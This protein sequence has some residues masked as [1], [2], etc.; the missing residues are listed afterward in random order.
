MTYKALTGPMKTHKDLKGP[1]QTYQDLHHRAARGNSSRC[2]P[3]PEAPQRFPE[4]ALRLR[5]RLGSL[6]GA[7][8]KG[9]PLER[10]TCVAL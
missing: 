3:P 9:I 8:G 10:S 6:W 1:T 5:E 2:T 7:P 4:G